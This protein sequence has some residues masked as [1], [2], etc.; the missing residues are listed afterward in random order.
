MGEALQQE[1]QITGAEAAAVLER[2]ISRP[3]TAAAAGALLE[4]GTATPPARGA[5]ATR[6][7]LAAASL[8]G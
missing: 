3:L 6:K 1:T 2:D 8:S 5:G 7:K 4:R